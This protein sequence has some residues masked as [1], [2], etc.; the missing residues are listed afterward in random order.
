MFEGLLL[1]NLDLVEEKIEKNPKLEQ[2]SDSIHTEDCVE[3]NVLRRKVS[4]IQFELEKTRNHF[5][6]LKQEYHQSVDYQTKSYEELKRKY[7]K[8][9]EEILPKIQKYFKNQNES[10]E[11]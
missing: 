1:P 4:E 11:N 10:Q 5:E 6:M 2:V 9:L 3:C 8:L 7:N